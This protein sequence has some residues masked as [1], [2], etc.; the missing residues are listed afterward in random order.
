MLPAVTESLMHQARQLVDAL[1]AMQEEDKQSLLKV[2]SVATRFDQDAVLLACTR[3]KAV[4]SKRSGIHTEMLD[5][6]ANPMVAMR[7]M[8]AFLRGKK[9]DA[10]FPEITESLKREA[11]LLVDALQAMKEDKRSLLGVLAVTTQF[12]PDAVLLACTRWKRAV[13]ERS[14]VDV[15]LLTQIANPM[16]AMRKTAAFVEEEASSEEQVTT[17]HL[18]APD[19]PEAELYEKLSAEHSSSVG[20]QGKKHTRQFVTL[21]FQALQ[22]MDTPTLASVLSIAGWFP[23]DIARLALVDGK[24]RVM[25]EAQVDKETVE[26]AQEFLLADNLDR[27]A[28]IIEDDMELNPDI[29][30][31]ESMVRALEAYPKDAVYALITRRWSRSAPTY[32][33]NIFGFQ[34]ALRTMARAISDDGEC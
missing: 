27:R 7:K 10:L 30:N 28:Q 5:R 13:S 8:D 17:T 23:D 31:A 29:C 18:F 25:R 34:A 3:W 6:V 32:I 1:E 11:R 4:V 19:S 22:R 26:K 9:A 33:K 16:V 20:S 15:E 21:M 12:P 24:A 2:L 14:G